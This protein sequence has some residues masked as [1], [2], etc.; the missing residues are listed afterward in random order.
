LFHQCFVAVQLTSEIH[1]LDAFSGWELRRS[2][3]V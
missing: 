1:K 3:T 2:A